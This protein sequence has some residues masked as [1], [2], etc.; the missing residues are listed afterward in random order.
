MRAPSFQF[1]VILHM[2]RDPLEIN[3]AQLSSMQNSVIGVNLN[4]STG[5]GKVNIVSCKNIFIQSSHLPWLLLISEAKEWLDKV[6][7][8]SIV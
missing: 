4:N 5:L 7:I 8:I 3:I 2:S 6:V 1:N